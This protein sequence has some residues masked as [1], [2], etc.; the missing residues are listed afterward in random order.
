MNKL[1][2]VILVSFFGLQASALTVSSFNLQ[3]YGLG[4][5][6]RGRPGN[7]Y[8][9]P[10]IRDF[11]E[12]NL[13]QSDVILFQ[14]IVLV[15]QLKQKLIPPEYACET[16]GKRRGEFHQYLVACVKK[17]WQFTIEAIED[18]DLTGYGRP[19]LAVNLKSKD[20]QAILRLIDVHLKAGTDDSNGQARNSQLAA[21]TAWLGRQDAKI[22][23][24][25]AGDFN[26]RDP[27]GLDNQL[28]AAGLVEAVLGDPTYISEPTRKN[29]NYDRFYV[30]RPLREKIRSRSVFQACTKSEMGG[31]KG[32]D[33]SDWLFYTRFIS[34]HCPI[35]MDLDL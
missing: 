32:D 15:D 9:D 4:G 12:K 29:F 5:N 35:T 34:D 10:H 20:G 1:L 22:Q 17:P 14:E 26:E 13:F 2:A 16:Y 31:K 19:G 30:S 24:V 21:L 33:Y 6:M 7:E 25:V 18:M 11:M 3:F 27:G 8:R 23:T 28:T